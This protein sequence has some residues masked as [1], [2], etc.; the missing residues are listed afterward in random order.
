MATPL[1]VPT[2]P[3]SGWN[4]TVVDLLEPSTAFLPSAEF[5]FTLYTPTLF[6]AESYSVYSDK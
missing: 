1:A 5:S 6:P 4:V 2:K 3:S